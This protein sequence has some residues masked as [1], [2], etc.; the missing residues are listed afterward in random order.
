MPIETLDDVLTWVQTCQHE[1]VTAVANP[2]L[3]QVLHLLWQTIQQQQGAVAQAKQLAQEAMA[4]ASA[5]LTVARAAQGR[6]AAGYA[7]GYENG[8][9]DGH[10]ACEEER[11]AHYAPAHR[12]N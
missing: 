10:K 11:Q 3:H 5:A 1:G 12:Q 9:E 8:Y 2:E 6:Y 4:Q 7:A